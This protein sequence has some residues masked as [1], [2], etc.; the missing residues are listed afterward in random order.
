MRTLHK[1]VPNPRRDRCK[2]TLVLTCCTKEKI[3]QHTPSPRITEQKM[4]SNIKTQRMLAMDTIFPSKAHAYKVPESVLKG[5]STFSFDVY[6]N[7][8]F[9]TWI[10]PCNHVTHTSFFI[11]ILGVLIRFS[12]LCGVEI[13][14]QNLEVFESVKLQF[15]LSSSLTVCILIYSFFQIFSKFFNKPWMDPS[16]TEFNRQRMVS[17]SVRMH[18]T[19]MDARRAAC[20]PY[21]LA[22]ANTCNDQESNFAPNV[23][24]VDSEKWLFCLHD[25]VEHALGHVEYDSNSMNENNTEWRRVTVPSN[26][27]LDPN[28]DDKPIY[29]NIKYPF[30]C[31]PP[32]IPKKNPT[33]I[34]KLNFD[35]PR[36]WWFNG[37]DLQD[38]ITI[39]FH[40][41]ESA[42]FLFINYEFVGYSQDSRLPASFDLTPN[43]RPQGNVMHVVVCRF[44]DGSY[45][46]DQ[47]HW[48][49]AGIHRSVEWNVFN[50]LFE[51]CPQFIF[52]FITDIGPLN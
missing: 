52:L 6:I 7:R 36:K 3:I 31:I 8:Y 33:G 23:W 25:T 50:F 43:I 38:E 22:T 16:Y 30:K 46:E 26:W 19:E 51:W 14:E 12:Y 44:S 17:S 28:V 1:A 48:W 21:L 34:Y 45:L 11:V 40:G 13:I 42:F 37:L 10:M 15:V 2:Y 20:S 41:V 9:T 32:F 35:L 47:D 49:M 18:V 27:T 5:E 24:N 4:K 29:T 39:T